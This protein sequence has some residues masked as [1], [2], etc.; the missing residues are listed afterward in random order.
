VTGRGTA[1]VR[2]MGIETRY[3]GLRYLEGDKEVGFA[4]SLEVG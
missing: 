3:K 4:P 2:G 1:K